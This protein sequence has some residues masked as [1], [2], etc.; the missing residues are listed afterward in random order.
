M[1][2]APDPRLTIATSRPRPDVGLV[3]LAGELDMATAPRVREHLRRQRPGPP[4]LVLDLTDVTFLGGAGITVLV[5]AAHDG[6]G[7]VHVVA[8]PVGPVRRALRLTGV[9]TVLPV[10]GDVEVALAAVDAQRS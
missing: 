4:V 2:A 3:A 1:S 7:A 9:D 8:A 10:H 5:E 6:V